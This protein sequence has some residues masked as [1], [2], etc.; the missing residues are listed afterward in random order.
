M[1]KNKIV[2]PKLPQVKRD[3]L[4]SEN[5]FF[6]DINDLDKFHDDLDN[7]EI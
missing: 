2:V 7:L 5:I 4:E 6:E 1:P 3:L